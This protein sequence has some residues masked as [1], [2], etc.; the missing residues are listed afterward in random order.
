MAKSKLTS[1]EAKDKT[2]RIIHCPLFKHQKHTD[3][4]TVLRAK[5]VCKM[6]CHSYFQF[7]KENEESVAKVIERYAPSIIDHRRRHG[8]ETDVDLVDYVMPAGDHLCKYCGKAFVHEGRLQKHLNTKHRRTLHEEAEKEEKRTEARER[9]GICSAG[10]HNGDRTSRGG[11]KDGARRGD[12]RRGRGAAVVLATRP[13]IGAP[14]V[15][16]HKLRDRVSAVDGGSKGSVPKGSGAGRGG[17]VLRAVPPTRGK[18]KSDQ[19]HKRKG[20]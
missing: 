20:R 15:R 14:I 3:A 19:A 12:L 9:K 6:Q 5:G 18:T 11:G 2:Y 8:L 4:C 17:R 10:D 13:P 1:S 16:V 7:A